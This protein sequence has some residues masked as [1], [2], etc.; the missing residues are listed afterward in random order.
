M[1]GGSRHYIGLGKLKRRYNPYI[2]VLI[3]IRGKATV[4]DVMWRICSCGYISATLFQGVR[5]LLPL[6]N[7]FF[8]L[9]LY[10][11]VKLVSAVESSV[12]ATRLP[13]VKKLECLRNTYWRKDTM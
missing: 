10:R 11:L 5:E 6:R 3:T 8:T 13:I 4:L 2:Y 9:I 1:I 12:I 7:N